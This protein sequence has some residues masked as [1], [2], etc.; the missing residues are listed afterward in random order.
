M[1]VLGT[2]SEELARDN[3]GVRFEVRVE[4]SAVVVIRVTRGSLRTIER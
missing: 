3:V 4:Q 2:A 1:V